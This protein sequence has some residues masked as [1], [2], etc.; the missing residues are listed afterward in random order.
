MGGIVGGK[1]NRCG[2]QPTMF[3]NAA[4]FALMGGGEAGDGRWG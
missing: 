2:G 3:A 4:G 1:S